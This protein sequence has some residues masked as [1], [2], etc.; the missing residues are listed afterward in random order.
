MSN[1]AGHP[2][3]DVLDELA[4]RILAYAA[5]ELSPE[6]T[7]LEVTAFADGDYRIRAFETRSVEPHP[8]LEGQAM[9][10]VAVAYDRRT[11]WITLQRTY[12]TKRDRV[13]AE[14]RE[15]E[16]YPDPVLLEGSE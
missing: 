12:E 5:D 3:L 4:D 7:T 15:L 16:A 2:R 11:E 10:R 1:R 8:T 6:K 9:E 14:T 13:V